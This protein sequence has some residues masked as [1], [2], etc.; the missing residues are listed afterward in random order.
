MLHSS[1]V[2]ILG[3]MG[4]YR[5]RGG[6]VIRSSLGRPKSTN[7]AIDR[8][9]ISQ[10]EKS[11]P[12]RCCNFQGFDPGI[13]LQN[14]CVGCETSLDIYWAEYQET[15]SESHTSLRKIGFLEWNEQRNTSLEKWTMEDNLVR[16]GFGQMNPSFC[17]L[18]AVVCSI[19]ITPNALDMIF[20]ISF[21][22]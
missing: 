17:C 6:V 14:G 12:L 16:W 3:N 5:F 21:P 19:Y 13:W 22:L 18:G 4:R 9:I 15:S 1:T 8:G 2:D 20:I 10:A 7:Q 11:L